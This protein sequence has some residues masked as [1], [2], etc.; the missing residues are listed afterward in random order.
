MLSTPGPS[1][2]THGTLA[3]WNDARGFGFITPAQ[4]V[5]QVFVH[6]SAFPRDGTRPRVGEPVSFDMDTDPRGRKRALRIARPAGRRA[7]GAGRHPRARKPVARRRA[8][9]LLGILALLAIGAYGYARLEPHAAVSPPS[10][11]RPARTLAAPS[12]SCDGRTRCSQMTSCAEAR[13]FLD[14]CPGTR[15]DGNHDGEPCEQQWCGSAGA[16]GS[17]PFR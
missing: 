11:A 2:R 14:H 12:F 9:P 6:I 10:I 4:G 15:M 5:E 16:N 3:T 7:T 8:K 1:K 13:Y 17:D